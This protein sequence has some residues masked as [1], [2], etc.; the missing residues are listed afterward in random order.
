MKTKVDVSNNLR[1]FFSNGFENAYD[2]NMSQI[3][4]KFVEESKTLYT[5]MLE[6]TRGNVVNDSN[7]DEL[8]KFASENFSDKQKVYN[9]KYDSFHI[10]PLDYSTNNIDIGIEPIP[11]GRDSIKHIYKVDGNIKYQ[12]RIG[13]VLFDLL[14]RYKAYEDFEPEELKSKMTSNMVDI[15]KDNITVPMS[16]CIPMSEKYEKSD[17]SPIYK[18]GIINVYTHLDKDDIYKIF[19]D[20]I[21]YKISSTEESINMLDFSNFREFFRSL[22]S[23]IIFELNKSGIIS[24]IL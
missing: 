20:I 16:Y 13:G 21:V 4:Q 10:Q 2:H 19:T 17:P 18:P 5:K 6:D 14:K 9:L 24:T 23:A 11:P 8:L 3:I 12:K 7:F 22:L 15:D 1:E